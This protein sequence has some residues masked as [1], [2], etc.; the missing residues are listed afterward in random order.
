VSP[1]Y[2]QISVDLQNALSSVFSNISQPSSALSSAASQIS[3]L[4]SS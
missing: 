2:L 3:S 4:P 1:Q